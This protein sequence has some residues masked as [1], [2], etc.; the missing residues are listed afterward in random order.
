MGGGRDELKKNQ[1]REC[2]EKNKDFCV[3][4][5]RFPDKMKIKVKEGSIPVA[6]KARRVPVKLVDKLKEIMFNLVNR[7][8]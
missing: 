2:I 4:M 1:I 3:R 5:G 8:L 7:K 6:Y